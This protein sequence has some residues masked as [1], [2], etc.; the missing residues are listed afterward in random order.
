MIALFFIGYGL[1]ACI[2]CPVAVALYRLTG[3]RA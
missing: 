3:A 1:I 2:A